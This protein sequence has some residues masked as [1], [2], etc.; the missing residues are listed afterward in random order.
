MANFDIN[1]AKAAL[2]KLIDEALAGQ[3]VVISRDG[4]EVVRLT[5]IPAPARREPRIPGRSKGKVWIS[6]DFEFTEEEIA[7]F[8][9]PYERRVAR[10]GSPDAESVA[11][12]RMMPR[13]INSDDFVAP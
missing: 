9:D 7:D 4:V 1:E 10:A 6:P 3:D 8:E 5:P 2:S 13:V 11:G 12:G